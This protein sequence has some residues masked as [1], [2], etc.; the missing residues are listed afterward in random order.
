MVSISNQAVA[1]LRE[2]LIHKCSEVGIGFRLLVSTDKSVKAAFSM[3]LDRQHQEDKVIDSGGVK[4][5]LDPSSDAEI[6]GYQLDYR[7]DGGFYLKTTD[8]SDDI[9]EGAN[10]IELTPR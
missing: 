8:I 6:R 3:K 10:E 2:Q 4:V 1:T 7:P 9:F 5:L